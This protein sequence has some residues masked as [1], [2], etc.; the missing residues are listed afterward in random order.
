MDYMVASPVSWCCISPDFVVRSDVVRLESRKP[1][2]I[3]HS[4]YLSTLHLT[5]AGRIGTGRIG[6]LLWP[7]S[8]ER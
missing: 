7:M 5:G 6:H 3:Y 1:E 4:E 8:T 2:H